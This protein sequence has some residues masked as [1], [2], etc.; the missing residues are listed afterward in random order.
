M[1]PIVSSVLIGIN[2]VDS[3]NYFNCY[4]YETRHHHG[5]NR[6]TLFLNVL[7]TSPHQII[8]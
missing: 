8:I 2:S 6:A 7:H 1:N 5:Q 4:I 3:T